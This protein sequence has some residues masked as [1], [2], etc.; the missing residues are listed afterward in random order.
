MEK[1]AYKME[2]V[3]ILRDLPSG[4]AA[5]LTKEPLALALFGRLSG[6]ERMYFIRR[7]RRAASQKEMDSVVQKLKRN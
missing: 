4:F 5:A 7:A 6:T 1:G 2:D 3:D